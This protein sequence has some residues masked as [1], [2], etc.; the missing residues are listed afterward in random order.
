[1][2]KE[3]PNH[4]PKETFLNRIAEAIA[5]MPYGQT[6]IILNPNPELEFFEV[7]EELTR[8]IEELQKTGKTQTSTGN[9]RLTQ[10][11]TG[12]YA[13]FK[14]TEERIQI[15]TQTIMIY[16]MNDNK[17]IIKNLPDTNL[18]N[19]FYVLTTAKLP[20]NTEGDV[21]ILN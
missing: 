13:V 1:M 17:D 10:P 11:I 20:P 14:D 7:Q 2:D 19:A 21:P 5:Q 16:Y 15:L 3:T 8:R 18:V 9:F 6:A 4:E 12:Q